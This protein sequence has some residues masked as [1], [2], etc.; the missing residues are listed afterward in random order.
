M[1]SRRE[2]A[3]EVG[4][5]DW[6]NGFV[7]MPLFSAGNSLLFQTALWETLKTH[8]HTK[9]LPFPAARAVPPAGAR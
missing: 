6:M 4:H 1:V 7:I 5:S 2:A 3:F 8:T 9:F